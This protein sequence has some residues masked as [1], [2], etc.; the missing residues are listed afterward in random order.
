MTDQF[1]ERPILNSPYEYPGRHC[2][3][4]GGQPTNQI[5]VARG[6]N[7][8]G[9][10]STPASAI[11]LSG[12]PEVM[13]G[14][15]RERCGAAVPLREGAD[16]F[17]RTTRVLPRTAKRYTDRGSAGRARPLDHGDRRP[18]RLVAARD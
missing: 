10:T 4:V 18:Y 13:A 5:T 9:K 2:E 3:L 6:Q 12:Q 8:C 1:F 16:E 14:L 17:G 15:T 7:G 11:M